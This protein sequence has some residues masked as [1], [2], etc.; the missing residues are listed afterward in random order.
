MVSAYSLD[1]SALV[2]RYIDESGSAWLRAIVDPA[3]NPFLVI[4]QLLVVEVHSALNRRLREGTISQDDYARTRQAFQGDCQNEYN[5]IPMTETIVDLACDLLER[6]PLRASDAIHLATALT[7]NRLLGNH[8]LPTLTFLCADD[9][10]LDA[11]TAEGL[12]TDNPNCHQ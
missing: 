5:L 2:K 10:L 9:R 6:H 4:S 12:A 11:A 3:L 8:G 1:T 7:S